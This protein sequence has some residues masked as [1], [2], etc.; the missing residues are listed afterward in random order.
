MSRLFLPL[1]LFALFLGC[2]S[3][4]EGGQSVADN[5]EKASESAPKSQGSFWIRP[6]RWKITMKMP[7]LQEGLIPT[8]EQCIDERQAHG[9]APLA[10]SPNP[11]DMR[12]CQFEK[13]KLEPGH[14]AFRLS[15][16]ESH[17]EADYRATENK[18][19]GVMTI[20]DAQTK[21]TQRMEIIA[22]RIGECP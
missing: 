14:Y 20:T 2:K 15:C 21:H 9:E 17:V 13:L 7:G 3:S 6:G 18:M 1:L 12:G 10:T 4:S 22:E 16:P 8:V 19:E 5:A 11:S